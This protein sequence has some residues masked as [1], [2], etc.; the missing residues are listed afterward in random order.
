[1]RIGMV[2]AASPRPVQNVRFASAVGVR[3]YEILD[4]VD[5]ERV[6][7]APLVD[8]TKMNADELQGLKDEIAID[9][10]FMLQLGE[11][12][13]AQLTPPPPTEAVP[14]G[15]PTWRPLSVLKRLLSGASS[16][17]RAIFQ[18]PPVID[19]NSLW[20]PR[21][22]SLNTTLKRMA[23]N[24][25]LKQYHPNPEEQVTRSRATQ[26]QITLTGKGLTY[27]QSLKA[28]GITRNMNEPPLKTASVLNYLH[29]FS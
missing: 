9:R 15:K 10:S 18:N 12:H 4:L 20:H 3:A 29:F 26:D 24:G 14:Q 11:R 1:M 19:V 25:W 23:E 17:G 13:Q 22:S 28:K 8:V 16:V 2:H 5:A 7:L 21:L 6:A 27:I